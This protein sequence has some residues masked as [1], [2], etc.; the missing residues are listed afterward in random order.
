MCDGPCKWYDMKIINV[1]WVPV[2]DEWQQD[3]QTLQEQWRITGSQMWLAASQLPWQNYRPVGTLYWCD[4]LLYSFRYTINCFSTAAET[5]SSRRNVKMKS[6]NKYHIECFAC[7]ES[8]MLTAQK[9]LAANKHPCRTHHL[10][11]CVNEWHS[12]VWWPEV[13]II[14]WA[15][16]HPIPRVTGLH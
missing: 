6:V 8:K 11:G 10:H 16:R 2:W 1:L 7:F 3:R 15:K 14:T 12:N 4:C 13:N 9:I 5:S